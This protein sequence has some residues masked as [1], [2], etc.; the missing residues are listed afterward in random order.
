MPGPNY[1]AVARP[2]AVPGR[3]RGDHRPLG[4]PPRSL[5]IPDDG[6]EAARDYLAVFLEHFTPKTVA[7][8][9]P[10]YQ[11]SILPDGEA[12]LRELGFEGEVVYPE[13]PGDEFPVGELNP[14]GW[15][16]SGR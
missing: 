8:H 4:R 15:P 1:S 9:T 5:P 13:F 12:L 3:P 2:L 11:L 6:V 16:E 10:R 14:A 7:L